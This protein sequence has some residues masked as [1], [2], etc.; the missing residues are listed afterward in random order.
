MALKTPMRRK[1]TRYP[2]PQYIFGS[3][4]QSVPRQS[5]TVYECLFFLVVLDEQLGGSRSS[6]HVNSHLC[7]RIKRCQAPTIAR[8]CKLSIRLRCV[9]STR[10]EQYTPTS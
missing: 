1:K 4:R 2:L 7:F 3:L 5:L 6:L 8:C 9:Y 10:R